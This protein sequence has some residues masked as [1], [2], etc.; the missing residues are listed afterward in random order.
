MTML[1]II[2]VDSNGAGKF[3]KLNLIAEPTALHAPR[4]T[5]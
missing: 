4:Q 3:P 1:E 2:D 5:N